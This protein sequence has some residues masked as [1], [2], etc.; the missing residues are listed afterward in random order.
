M[1]DH[2]FSFTP[3]P[4]R[5]R[6]LL[7]TFM[8][9]AIM[10]C[11]LVATLVQATFNRHDLLLTHDE[12]EHLTVMF[13][14]ER[15]ERPYRDFIENHPLLP[16]VLLSKLRHVAGVEDSR[17][18]Y[19][20][21]KGLVFLHFLGCLAL[22]VAWLQRHR[23]KLM[24][25]LPPLLTLPVA[26]ALLGAWT[27]REMERESL[28][29]LRPDWVCYF[30]A[31]L[32]AMCA[33]GATRAETWRVTA[34][35]VA[36]AAACAGLATALLPKS[37][38]IL[39]PMGLALT[40]ATAY[41]MAGQRIDWVRLKRFALILLSFGVGTV[42]VWA[43][44]V[45]YELHETGVDWQTYWTA[46]VA[47]NSRMH[48]VMLAED[49]SAVSQLRRLSGF[50]LPVALLVLWW[51]LVGAERARH[52]RQWLRYGL[53]CNCGLT[54]LLN[55]ALPSFSNGLS[56]EHYFIPAM[57]VFV[58]V[59]TLMLDALASWAFVITP[60]TRHLQS[61]WVRRLLRLLVPLVLVV[62]VL[63]VYAQRWID[64]SARQRDLLASEQ[65]AATLYPGMAASP[66][67]DY[68]LPVD[69]SYLSRT[70]ANKPLRARGWGYFFMLSADRGLWQSAHE[71]GLAPDPAKHW[72]TLY[73]AEPPD[74]IRFGSV[75][76]LQSF[77]RMVYRMQGADLG[78]IEQ[79][80]ARDYRCMQ[81]LG[82]RVHVHRMQVAR[83]E[84]EHWV[85]C[86][87]QEEIPL[88]KV[89]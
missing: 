60:K 53:L 5:K 43:A 3:T 10:A 35:R 77:L 82:T 41:R 17:E 76:E 30:W 9:L 2:Y 28:W 75:A 16:H 7:A 83:F 47:M 78:W 39:V 48:L 4:L 29:Q 84:S 44:L 69:L 26:V 31:L 34:V 42:M 88:W 64:I 50:S 21:A 57:L 27:L 89:L 1:F 61:P 52:R 65:L 14:V 18:L 55:V 11:V 37:V 15:G 19:R 67:P 80:M 23:R 62:A 68:L 38:L 70:P 6:A 36:V 85:A 46:N 45:E 20:F 71:L 56:W 8:A 81:R 40:L 22:L 12:A 54:L 59:N 72:R 24:L 63:G 49:L 32:S 79:A 74:V 33:V 58:T 51:G 87:V 25:H 86:R 73:A 66:L 13:A